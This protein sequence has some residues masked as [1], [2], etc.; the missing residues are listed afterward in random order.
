LGSADLRNAGLLTGLVRPV[1]LAVR[2]G[3]ER[4]AVRGDLALLQG[5]GVKVS[6]SLLDEN[7]LLA[8]PEGSDRC[9]AGS[10]L[11]EETR[12]GSVGAI[13]FGESVC[14]G[15]VMRGGK[16]SLPDESAF[17]VRRIKAMPSLLDDDVPVVGGRRLESRAVGSPSSLGSLSGE[18][19]AFLAELRVGE[20]G[21][22]D[23][24]V[25]LADDCAVGEGIGDDRCRDAADS[26]GGGR[27][28][29]TS[30]LSNA[31]TSVAFD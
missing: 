4:L 24:E 10:S 13:D 12:N 7:C 3:D 22:T 15:L 16:P 26:C 6:P 9:G 25:Y 8:F 14:A 21:R 28:F 1:R 29:G 31:L 19:A 18:D 20:R 2:S 23:S 30:L 5:T 17:G 27:D 11:L